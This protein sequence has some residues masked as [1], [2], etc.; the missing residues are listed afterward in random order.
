MTTTLATITPLGRAAVLPSVPSAMGNGA[1][2]KHLKFSY[3]DSPPQILVV[4]NSAVPQLTPLDVGHPGDSFDPGDPWYGTLDPSQRGQAFNNQFGFL[5]DEIVPRPPNTTIWFRFIASSPGVEFYQ[6]MASPK[7]WTPIFGTAGS[8]SVLPWNAAMFHPFAATEP[9][10]GTAWALLEAFLANT[11]TGEDVPGV[12]PV[13]FT[14]NWTNV[15]SATELSIANA[16]VITWSTNA[17]NYTL[18]SAPDLSST[19]WTPVTNEPVVMEG[20]N[21]VVLPPVE[22]Q[23]VFRLI[24]TP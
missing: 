9:A 13:R 8:T 6:Y 11:I 18:H 7:M 4:T 12:A 20:K 17:T 15:A 24:N 2:M 3:D 19:N 1:L 5:Y 21:A 22:P 23:Q 16:V 14:L 10:N